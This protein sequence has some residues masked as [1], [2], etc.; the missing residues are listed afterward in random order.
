MAPLRARVTR[1][2]PVLAARLLSAS[3]DG[4]VVVVVEDR[5]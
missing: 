5:T 2:R 3:D 4:I 1:S